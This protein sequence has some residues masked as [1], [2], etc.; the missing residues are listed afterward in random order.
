MDDLVLELDKDDQEIVLELDKDEQDIVLDNDVPYYSG[1]TKDYE[2]LINKPRINDVE[3]I[4]NKELSEL[5]VQKELPEITNL[6]ILEI[7]R[8]G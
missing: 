7:F 1:L 5:G 3:L 8:K 2:K 6:E 4:G